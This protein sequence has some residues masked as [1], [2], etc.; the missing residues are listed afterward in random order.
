M[1]KRFNDA[2]AQVGLTL[3]QARVLVYLDRNEGISQKSL[4]EILEIQPITLLRQVDRLAES[5]LLER[6]PN[7]T[8]RRA[9]C[10]HVTA[11]GRDVLEMV[12]KVGRAVN[13]NAFDGVDADDRAAMEAILTVVRDNLSVR[14]RAGEE[15]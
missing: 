6:R 11:T 13:A 3:A 7:P 9:Q 15:A 1:R 10:L 12:W 8:D 14:V 4:A 5:G 2:A